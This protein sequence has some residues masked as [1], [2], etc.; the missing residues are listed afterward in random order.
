MNI[1]NLTIAPAAA[2]AI[3]DTTGK[4]LG[5]F[6]PYPAGLATPI[7]ST[8]VKPPLPPS[9]F[10]ALWLD[11]GK[12]I[13]LMDS[14]GNVTQINSTLLPSSLSAHG[15][16]IGQDKSAL[17]SVLPQTAGYVLTSNGPTADPSF[18]A[19]NP[20][21]AS[22]S[23]LI[24]VLNRA[25]A[26]PAGS[27]A[28][29]WVDYSGYLNLLFSGTT[30]QFNPALLPS[31]VPAN[32]VL[33]GNVA[34]Q[35]KSAAPIA[36]GYVLTD[37]GPTLPPSF[38]AIPA[39]PGIQGPKG[40]TGATGTGSIGPAG[41]KGDPGN[42]LSVN[43]QTGISYVLVLGDNLGFVTMTNTASNSV[44]IPSNASVPFPTGA[45]ITIQQRG[46]GQV[47][48]RGAGGVTVDSTGGTPSAPKI[49]AQYGAASL[50]KLSTDAWTVIGNIV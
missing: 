24:P 2:L 31:S 27:F 8:G 17:N 40:D 50:V 49:L 23:W 1:D 4:L 11:S 30:Y 29:L 39:M 25:P 34:N 7:L 44:T 41:P 28:A 22:T 38:Q 48:I 36:A 18:Q 45:Q 37:N 16:L 5:Y 35:L 19:L 42:S 26:Q 21:N 10:F 20:N 15:V 33:L 14:S 43:N 9:G 32:A 47:T 12:L 46:I 6:G 3:Y 13:N